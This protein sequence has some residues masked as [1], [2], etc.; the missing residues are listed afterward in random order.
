MGVKTQ[1]VDILLK[2]AVIITMNGLREIIRG[3]YIAVR[4]TDIVAVGAGDDAPESAGKVIDC[5]GGIV[6]PG[7]INCHSHAGHSVMGKL[8]TDTLEDWW[9]MLIAVYEN[10]ATKDF[11]NLDGRLHACQTIRKGITT[12]A[13]VMGSTPMGDEP[14]FPESHARGF[15]SVGAREAIGV[16]I[17]YGPYPKSYTRPMDGKM[18]KKCAT[19]DDML[20]GTEEAIRRIHMK[21]GGLTRVMVTPHQQLMEHEPG[22]HGERT[23]LSL[24]KG[25]IALNARIRALARKYGTRIYTDTY[26]GWVLTAYLDKENMLLGPDTL[27]GMEHVMATGYDEVDILAKT[28]SN[29]YYTAEGYYKR[30]PICALIEA[31][32]NVAITTNAC[33]PRTTLDLLESLRRAILAEQIFADSTA[34][35]QSAKALETVTIDAAKALGWDDEIGSIEIGKKADIAVL[36][37]ANGWISPGVSPVQRVVYDATGGDFAHVLVNGRMIMH[38]RM[39]VTANESDIMREAEETHARIVR[40]IGLDSAIN[41]PV[42]GK[43]RILSI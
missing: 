8:N 38:D 2:N 40:D 35:F 29:V 5:K 13:N 6:I 30:V 16:G 24:T 27:I 19:Y 14:D 10:Y 33:A 9:S 22:V 32:V 17:P 31:G 3:G 28:G 34:F 4:G 7:L 42:F 37:A 43:I 1:M 18:A 23:L 21:N 20:A 12:T 11:W 39:I 36:D 25:E 15:A 41:Q 26:G